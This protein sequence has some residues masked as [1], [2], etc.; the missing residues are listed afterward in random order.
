MEAFE[1]WLSVRAQAGRTVGSSQW[2]GGGGG[3]SVDLNVA[4]ITKGRVKAQAQ[5]RVAHRDPVYPPQASRDAVG[6]WRA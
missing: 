5:S 1:W 2:R 4:L 3:L 6:L